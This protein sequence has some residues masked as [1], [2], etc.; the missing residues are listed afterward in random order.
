ML[1]R[2]REMT[3]GWQAWHR[4]LAV[5]FCAQLCTAI[6]FSIIFP[7]LP[8]YVADL[9]VSGNLGVEFWS[10][11]VFSSQGITM[12]IASPFWGALADRYGRKLMVQRAMFGGTIIIAL[13]AFA[14]SAEE[15]VLLRA[16]QGL[17]TGTVAAANALVASQ[18]P[19][20][21]TGFAMGV[22]QVGLWGGVSLGPLIGGVLAD[23]FGFRIPFLVTAALLFVSGVLV[24]VLIQEDFTEEQR[25][26]GR[27]KS[28]RG[29]LTHVVTMP[30]V[31]Q[32]YTIRF[33]SALTRS[34][35][36][37]ITPLFVMM[38]I[39][40]AGLDARTL[41]PQTGL[42]LDIMLPGSEG[43]STYTGLV[44]GISSAAATISAVYLGRWGDRI[45]HRR[46]LIGSAIFATVFYLPQ[47]LVTAPW[48]L[49][50]L[51]GIGGLAVGG[52]VSAPSALLARYTD[53]GEEG[54]VY[55]LDNS[56][57]AGGRALAPLVGAAVAV[58]FGLRAVYASLGLVLIVVLAVVM[59][60]LP[61]DQPLV[62]LRD[63]DEIIHAVPAP[64][65]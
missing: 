21:H 19:R 3:S 22:I 27:S 2:I 45:G 41:I 64:G 37:P 47:A 18:A 65:D 52:M 57:V 38:L 24:T 40:N 50:A 62:D 28:F 12:M 46:I 23:S 63:E 48:Q 14:R 53:P 16:I 44:V 32:T 55:G 60:L 35:I 51:Q 54:A 43:V 13:M 36:V 30:G 39:L 34:M 8:L 9:G 59:V 10:G 29:E 33:L 61:A 17:I 15:L 31:V 1:G 11:M 26:A 58:A 4:T 6:G 49:L 42:F 56:V 25:E 7:F 5:V 20:K